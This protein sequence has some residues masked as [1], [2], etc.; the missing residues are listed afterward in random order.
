MIYGELGRTGIDVSVVGLGTEYLQNAPR[1]HVVETVGALLDAGG[2]Y[3]DAL[4]AFPAYRDHLAVAIKGKRDQVVLAGHLGCGVTEDG[5]YRKTRDVAEAEAYFEDLL[6]R[7]G[8]DHVDVLLLQWIDTSTELKQA[9]GSAGLLELARRLKQQGKA[10]AIGISV[11]KVRVARAA[12]ES[13]E[14]DMLMF[15]VN[16]AWNII[17]GRNSLLQACAERGVGVVAM[18]PYAGGRLVDDP[19]GHS[20]T[21]TQCIAYCLDQPA[22]CAVVPGAKTGEEMRQAL[23]YVDASPDERSYAS[24]LQDYQQDLVGNCVYC[25]HC[26][27]CPAGIDIGYTLRRLDAARPEQATLGRMSRKQRAEKMDFYF[28]A[29]KPERFDFMGKSAM[30]SACTEC[31]DCMKRCPFGVDVIAKMRLATRITTDTQRTRTGEFSVPSP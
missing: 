27:P 1:E 5:Q 21:P 9:M 22:V 15:P 3:I 17:P 16:L 30:A 10:R 11:H 12:I 7:L 4:Y 2:T 19:Q 28:G 14:F 6:C 29:A 26:L 31:K 20:L 13:D 8:T 18:K 23:H 24:V 25:N